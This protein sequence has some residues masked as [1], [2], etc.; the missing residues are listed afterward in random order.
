MLL[1]YLST[2][3]VPKNTILQRPGDV[4]TAVYVVKRGILRSYSLDAKG[5]EHIFL[6]A[7]ENW[8]IADACPHDEPASLFIDAIADSE[9][10]VHP[11]QEHLE[12][13]GDDMLRRRLT[14]LYNRM[15]VLQQRVIQLM[16]ASALE[17]YE[18]FIQTYPDV[19]QRVPQRMVASYLGL[20]PEALSKVK[21]EALRQERTS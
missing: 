8:I 5:R 12:T 9:V 6:F 15:G 3:H 19:T 1:L 21:N 7:P 2:V 11:K 18:S 17:R 20:T 13:S 10:E 4:N 14:G 16:S